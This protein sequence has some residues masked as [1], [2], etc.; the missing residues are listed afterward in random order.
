MDFRWRSHFQCHFLVK[1]PHK[2]RTPPSYNPYHVLA[3]DTPIIY[4]N[5]LQVCSH[6]ISKSQPSYSVLTVWAT[7]I[8]LLTGLQYCIVVK[9]HKHDERAQSQH[10][11][12]ES[13]SSNNKKMYKVFQ[14]WNM[15]QNLY[16]TVYTFD[17]CLCCVVK[18][19]RA[20]SRKTPDLLYICKHW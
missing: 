14:Q 19:E 4:L 18:R 17:L 2:A 11:S 7:K 8:T 10:P 13:I 12:E 9:I 6:T 3:C 1:L 20:V 16:N 5:L 15:F